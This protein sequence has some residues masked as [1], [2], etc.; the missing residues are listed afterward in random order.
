MRACQ[1]CGAPAGPGDELC[2][3]CGSPVY[4]QL[5]DEE[6]EALVKVFLESQDKALKGLNGPRV[7][8]AFAALVV[9]P[10][11]A[12]FGSR[13]L[14]AG[15]LVATSAVLFVI[16]ACFAG[17]GGAVQVEQ[18]LHFDRTVKGKIGEFL[19]ENRLEKARFLLA[20]HKGMPPDSEVMKRLAK[21]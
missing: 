15:W 9:L 21:L 18:D 5:T 11:A 13:A 20:A 19:Q 6:T 1:K 14:G 10:F 4:R 7:W 12:Y 8:A 2:R 17:V 16:A 3:F